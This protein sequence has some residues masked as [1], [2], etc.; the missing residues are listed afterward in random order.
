M[1]GSRSPSAAPHLSSVNYEL[2]D[3]VNPQ[4]GKSLDLL[5]LWLPPRDNGL[6]LSSS[7]TLMG[8][9]DVL[10]VEIRSSLE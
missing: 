7:A 5:G 9:C 8:S 6:Q 3:R 4:T 1:L 2:F 10:R